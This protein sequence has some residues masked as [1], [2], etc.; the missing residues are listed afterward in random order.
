[1]VIWLLSFVSGFP[2]FQEQVLQ[3]HQIGKGF[4]PELKFSWFHLK[5]QTKSS[6]SEMTIGHQILFS[7]P[8]VAGKEWRSL[9]SLKSI[10]QGQAETGFQFSLFLV[11]ICLFVMGTSAFRRVPLKKNLRRHQKV[12]TKQ[13]LDDLSV[14]MS[15]T[16]GFYYS[17]NNTWV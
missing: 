1:M 3:C 14:N 15:E 11:L 13:H 9:P 12:L 10:P 4:L 17:W 2:R 6:N 8:P 5:L 16:H 7:A